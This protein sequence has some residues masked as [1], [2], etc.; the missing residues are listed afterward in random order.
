M[1]KGKAMT[2]VFC[3]KGVGRKET[4]FFK[5]EVE[6]VSIIR[7]QNTFKDGGMLSGGRCK[8]KARN[9]RMQKVG[10]REGRRTRN[11]EEIFRGA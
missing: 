6:S 5:E 3:K 8:G 10:V 1:P 11:S 9:D 7:M 4:M 2:Q